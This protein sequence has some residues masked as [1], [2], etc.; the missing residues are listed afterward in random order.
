MEAQEY[1]KDSIRWIVV[2][3][4][5]DPEQGWENPTRR[6][7]GR[8]TVAELRN[9]CIDLALAEH[10]DYIV[11]WDDDDYYPPKRI[12]SG[13]AALEFDST[14]EIAASSKMFL[15]LTRENVMMTTGPCHETHGTAAT[16]TI[17]RSYAETHRFD[18]SKA[19]GEELS[20]TNGWTAPMVHV[21]PEDTIV[22]MG[23]GRNTVDKSDLLKRPHVYNA[24]IV[25]DSN[26]K[27]WMRSRWPVPWGLF[28]STFSV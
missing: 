22:V 16:F 4:S 18:P 7:E 24:K 19:K 14:K 28:R 11:F 20:F 12:S 15:L 3:N 23:H 17:R 21:S 1:P 10:P 6:V 26:G 27:M 8:R 9:I 13:V 25:N 2:D 5:D